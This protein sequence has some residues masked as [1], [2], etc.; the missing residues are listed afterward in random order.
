M[1]RETVGDC[2]G[3]SVELLAEYLRALKRKKEKNISYVASKVFVNI[4]VHVVGFIA[5]QKHAWGTWWET[6]KNDEYT[7]VRKIKCYC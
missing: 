2:E 4:V 7:K 3:I 6:T 5:P 1:D